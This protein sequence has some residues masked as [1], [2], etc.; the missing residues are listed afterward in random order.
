MTR[1]ESLRT[2]IL[3]TAGTGLTL[4]GCNPITPAEE[5]E[6]AAASNNFYGRTPEETKRDERLHSETF[7]APHELA[8]ITV[9]ANLIMPP[10]RHG[11]IEEAE[12]PEFI[13]FIAKDVP[14][15]QVPI[16]GGLAWLN[17][18]SQQLFAEEFIELEEVQQK[19][20]LD[21]IAFYDPDMPS[22]KRPQP[23]NFFSLMRG[24][25]C[26]GYFTSAVGIA[27][28]GYKGNQANIWDGVPQEVLD[29]HGVAY[30][31]AWLA[32]CVDQSKREIIAEWD[33]HGNLLT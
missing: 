27:D 9:L 14:T 5:A 13:E 18:T 26:T 8:T 1:R 29:K 7:F 17:H 32:K 16:R 6:I 3:G 21:E 11:G 19:E 15:Y 25:V 30:D 23:V 31:P 2:L 4:T 10:S 24:L 12:V 28:L 20:I 33:E 22:S